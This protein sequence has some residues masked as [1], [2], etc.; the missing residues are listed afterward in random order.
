MAGYVEDELFDA[1]KGAGFTLGTWDPLAADDED[2]SVHRAMD[3]VANKETPHV[4]TLDVAASQPHLPDDMVGQKLDQFSLLL[5]DTPVFHT[6]LPHAAFPTFLTPFDEAGPQHNAL[7]T[8]ACPSLQILY[9]PRDAPLL[10]TLYMLCDQ[11]FAAA[12]GA[13][14]SERIDDMATLLEDYLKLV[15]GFGNP[16]T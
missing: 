1:S 16:Q 3:Q 5:V 11:R 9:E 7:D 4:P 12:A 10:Q 15:G 14:L 13:S 8:F 2:P 6:D